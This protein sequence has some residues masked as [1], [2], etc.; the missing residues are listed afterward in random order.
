MAKAKGINDDYKMLDSM[1]KELA[2]H[3]KTIAALGKKLTK[4][5]VRLDLKVDLVENLEIV[6]DH[7]RNAQ[8]ELE[9]AKNRLKL[10]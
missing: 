2:S 9:K 5:K 10:I 6:Y 3:Q 4:N 8:K 1:S 7:M